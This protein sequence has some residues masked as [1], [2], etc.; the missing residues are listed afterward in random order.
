MNPGLWNGTKHQSGHQNY[1]N[2]ISIYKQTILPFFDYAGFILIPCNSKDRADLQITDVRL[3]D[4]LSLSEMHCEANL[5]S[6][7]QRIY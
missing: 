3:L 2:A 4:C 1:V 5:D 6:L 7:K